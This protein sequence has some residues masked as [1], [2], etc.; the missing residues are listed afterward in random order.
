[1]LSELLLD[2]FASPFERGSTRAEPAVRAIEAAWSVHLIYEVTDEGTRIRHD[3]DRTA[4]L[5]SDPRGALPFLATPDDEPHATLTGVVEPGILA[6]CGVDELHIHGELPPLDAT[7]TGNGL[8]LFSA[9][10]AATWAMSPRRQRMRRSSS[11]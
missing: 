11:R 10:L 8:E 7:Q 1:V 9:A 6:P 4:Y 2:A 5:A 3:H